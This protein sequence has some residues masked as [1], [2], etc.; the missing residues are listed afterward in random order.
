MPGQAEIEALLTRAQVGFLA[1][2]VD[3]Q[4]FLHPSL[5]WYD[6]PARRIYLHTALAGRTH[7]NVLANPRVS[8]SVAELGRLLPAKTALN[9]S[10]EYASVC[11]FGQ[12]RI[13]GTD[14]EKR[15]GLQGQLA[16]YFPDLHPG[17][18]YRPITDEEMA[19]TSVY[20]VEIEGWSGKQKPVPE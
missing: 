11:L 16:K 19:Q 13:V 9:F 15:H 2:S 17:A 6:A 10:N 14:E 3:D 18:D 20:A 8:F 7:D 5:F 1:T 12:A 4:P